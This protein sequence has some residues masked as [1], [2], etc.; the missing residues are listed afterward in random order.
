MINALS[1]CF[2]KS[3]DSDDDFRLRDA[4]CLLAFGMRNVLPVSVIR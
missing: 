1:G 4:L 2:G 3:G